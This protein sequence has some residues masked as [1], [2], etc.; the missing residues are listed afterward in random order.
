[1][2]LE[3]ALLLDPDDT[4]WSA[5]VPAGWGQGRTAFGGLVAAYLARAVE[6]GH[7]RS[8][9]G[10]DT[11]FLAPVAPGPIR[12]EQ[13]H[14]R[15]GKYVSH[16]EMAMIQGD[17]KVAVGRF[18]LAEDTPGVVDA[19][20]APGLPEKDFE[21]A[22]VMPYIDGVT[23]E[24]SKH[25]DIRIGEGEIP[26]SGS[27]R[28][29]TGGFVRNSGP[30]NGVAALLTHIDAW[31]PPVLSLVDR[32]AAASTVRWH[33]Q[34]HADVKAVDGQ[35]WSWFRSESQWRTGRLATVVGSLVRDGRSVA[36]CEQ[37]VAMYL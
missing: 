35:Q 2:D 15:S 13:T 26:F 36:Y 24:F 29:V 32:P 17:E 3:T 30:A 18:L 27:S 33:V 31:P 22:L 37:T 11:F 5:V 7:D 14:E 23:P 8:V 34:F 1:M 20:P 6:A 19:V 28:A 10:A 12:L 16:V 9:H 25:F 4:G 21:A